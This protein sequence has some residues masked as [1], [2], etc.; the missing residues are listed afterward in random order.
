MSFDILLFRCKLQGLFKT[1]F[2][3]IEISTLNMNNAEVMLAL[4]MKGINLK[5][6]GK[7]FYNQRLVW[8][9]LTCY[10]SFQL[11]QDLFCSL[12]ICHQ[13]ESDPSHVLDDDDEAEAAVPT[14]Q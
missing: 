11:C 14:P 4:Y 10:N 8:I 5:N 1:N 3:C 13:G 6:P 9:D 2:S 12:C 7:K